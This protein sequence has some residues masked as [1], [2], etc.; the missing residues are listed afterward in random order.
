MSKYDWKAWGGYL[1][2]AA[3]ACLV[4]SFTPIDQ[5]RL[6]WDLAF[7]R[8]ADGFERIPAAIHVS[9][10]VGV[11]T[12]S[13][14]LPWLSQWWL[15]KVYEWL[16]LPA[17]VA[18]KAC[19]LGLMAWVGVALGQHGKALTRPDVGILTVWALVAGLLVQPSSA[20][21]GAAFLALTLVAVMRGGRW[22]VV[23]TLLAPV[24]V[25]VDASFV[26][27]ALVLVLVASVTR[28]RAALLGAAGF[29]AGTFIS[30]RGVSVWVGAMEYVSWPNLATVS[31]AL[32]IGAFAWLLRESSVEGRRDLAVAGAV[33]LGGL[34]FGAIPSLLLGGF[35][36]V[37]RLEGKAFGGW[38]ALGSGV[39]A[40]AVAVLM[41]PLWMW[42]RPLAER[43]GIPEVSSAIPLQAAE[44]VASWGGMRRF[45]NPPEFAGLIVWHLT[46]TGL[47]PVVFRDHRPL[48]PEFDAL[49]ETIETRTGV[50]RGVFQQHNVS[51]ALLALPAQ[52]RLAEEMAADPE[53]SVVWESDAAVL[54]MK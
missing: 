44:I 19:L 4:A 13:M 33:A 5:P 11:E 43:L 6:W 24:W 39:A 52:K 49:Q 34:V 50:W 54:L 7:G 45:Y 36:F 48:A 27:G 10:L 20:L 26:I 47:H 28:T 51:A 18:L 29:V 9:Y 17:L 35:V 46:S 38:S 23:P 2:P 3:V 15:F 32:A 42:H 40:L 37:G 1:I 41:L 14:I 16:E 53:W 21:F 8:A 25:N 22:W 31:L 12:P 30:P